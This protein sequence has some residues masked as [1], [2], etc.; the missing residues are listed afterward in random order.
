[1]TDEKSF[2]RNFSKDALLIAASTM[3]TAPASNDTVAAAVSTAIALA[4][5]IERREGEEPSI[6]EKRGVTTI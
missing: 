2:P 4:L 1:M 6:Y 5:E 3:I